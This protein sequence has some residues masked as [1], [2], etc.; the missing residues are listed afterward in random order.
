MMRMGVSI[1]QQDPWI[2]NGFIQAPPHQKS[3][4]WMDASRHPPQVV[5]HKPDGPIGLWRWIKQWQQ[6]GSPFH[7]NG[8]GQGLR[9][10]DSD[11]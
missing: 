2:P 10:Y 7:F 6:L 4:I 3:K 8:I 9:G 11:A 5:F 1:G